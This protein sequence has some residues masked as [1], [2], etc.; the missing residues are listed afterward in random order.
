MLGHVLAD[1]RDP[2]GDRVSRDVGAGLELDEALEQVVGP[3]LAR[4]GLGLGA[5]ISLEPVLGHTVSIWNRFRDPKILVAM[6]LDR[7]RDACRD[8]GS[9]S[10]AEVGLAGLDLI[11][12]FLYSRVGNPADAEDLTQQVALKALHRLREGATEASIRAYLFVTARSVLS[13]FWSNRYRMPEAELGE[14]MPDDGRGEAI[15]TPLEAAAWLELTLASLPVHYR[16]VLELRFLQSCSL[17]D[18]ALQMGK[19]VGAVKLMQMRAL[20]SAAQVMKPDAG[21]TAPPRFPGER[22]QLEAVPD[23]ASAPRPEDRAS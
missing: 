11:Y 3:V 16:R 22:P 4:R 7:E 18:T 6:Y 17:R 5:V 23:S 2:S 20:R 9:R 12:P 8:G 19:S 1:P 15:E 13:A 10:A 14:D 21:F